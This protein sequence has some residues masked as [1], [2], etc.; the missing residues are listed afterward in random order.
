MVQDHFWKN[1]FLTHFRP[2]LGPKTAHFQ[3]ILG[4]SMAQNAPPPAQNG[5]KTLVRATKWSEKIFEKKSFFRPGDPGGPTMG[6]CRA[7]A[8]L[9]SNSTK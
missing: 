1:V 8:G 4:F 9:P 6:P 7:R 3:G 2:I 5:L